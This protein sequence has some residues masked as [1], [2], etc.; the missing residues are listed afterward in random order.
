MFGDQLR[1][2]SAWMAAAGIDELELSGPSLRLQLA[3]DGGETIPDRTR[4]QQFG[5]PPRHDQ[6]L[7][8]VAASSVGVFLDRHPLHESALAPAGTPVRAGQIVGLLQA[9][10][11]LVPVLAPRD[12]RIGATLVPHGTLVGFGTSLIELQSIER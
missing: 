8:I 1:E 3:R 11:L 6:P 5:E 4:D 10:T 9:G 12:G 7:S 2:L